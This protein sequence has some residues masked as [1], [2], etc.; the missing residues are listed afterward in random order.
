MSALVDSSILANSPDVLCIHLNGRVGD[1]PE[2]TFSDRQYGE[3]TARPDPWYQHLVADLSNK[4]V[5]FVGTQLDEPP[6][7]Q[8]LELRGARHRRSRELRPGSYL[9]APHVSL[10]RQSMLSDLN[11]EW[12]Q[13]GQVEFATS[14]LAEMIEARAQGMKVLSE[15]SERRTP[16][17]FVLLDSIEPAQGVDLAE[18]LRGREPR[19]EDLTDGYAVEREFE[20]ALM[21]QLEPTGQLSAWSR[22]RRD[23]ARPRR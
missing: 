4:P 13:M 20:R 17:A 6:L 22:A 3:R 23:Q 5:V 16:K 15:R 9:V 10:G 11:I 19:W 7:W 18:Y 14:V 1:Y 21:E 2:M 12:I 8:H